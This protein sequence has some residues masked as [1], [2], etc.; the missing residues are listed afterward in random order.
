M[1]KPIPDNLQEFLQ[2]EDLKAYLGGDYPKWLPRFTRLLEKRPKIG[3]MRSAFSWN[4]MA[5]LVALIYPPGWFFL[6]K[7]W[8]MAWLLLVL[9]L[10]AAI[11][12]PAG[13]MLAGI[14][15]I[16]AGRE[17]NNAK[18]VAAYKA[19]TKAR[20][21][22][23]DENMR[24]TVLQGAGK[25]NW[26]AAWGTLV[27][28]FFIVIMITVGQDIAAN[29]GAYSSMPSSTQS[30]SRSG[31]S[32]TCGSGYSR[33]DVYDLNANSRSYAGRS[34][35]ARGYMIAMM[36]GG[37]SQGMPRPRSSEFANITTVKFDR[38]S[39][40][41]RSN[42]A[43]RCGSGGCRVTVCGRFIVQTYETYLAAESVRIR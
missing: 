1:R 41:D 33:V 16:F 15:I 17:A 6:N 24:R 10:L 7:S 21:A 40:S 35:E 14:A 27:I 23:S 22:F 20:Q 42:I 32:G 30:S 25:N 18:L 2:S 38:L 43:R 28:Y 4:W 9:S 36:V 8:F 39:S 19:V 5:F 37:M 29:P 31:S 26:G 13:G 11:T 34:V 12:F 3:G